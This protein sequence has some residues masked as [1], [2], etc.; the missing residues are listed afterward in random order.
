MSKHTDRDKYLVV[1]PWDEMS[2]R[3]CELHIG[4]ICGSAVVEKLTVSKARA[5]SCITLSYRHKPYITKQ[6]E[7]LTYLSRF[8]NTNHLLHSQH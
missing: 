8:L 5:Q 3:L 7:Q 6:R 1:L 4:G 2:L